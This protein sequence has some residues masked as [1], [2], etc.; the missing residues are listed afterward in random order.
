M[1]ANQIIAADDTRSRRPVAG[2]PRVFPITRDVLK[3]VL[4]ILIGVVMAAPFLWM[5]STSLKPPDQI[6]RIPPEWIPSRFVWRNYAEAWTAV[7]FHLFLLNSTKVSGLAVM[8]ALFVCS[9]AGY[10][11]AKVKFPGSGVVFGFLLATLMI[12]SAVRLIP[13]YI[14]FRRIGWID[15]HYTLIVPPVVASTFGTFLMRQFFITLPSEL[16][17]SAWVDGCGVW[18][19]YWRIMLPLA[20]PGLGVLAIFMFMSSWNE[21]LGPLIFINT[22]EK[23]TAPLGLAAFQGEYGTLWGPLMAGSTII[24]LPV[25]IVYLLFQRTFTEGIALSGLK[26]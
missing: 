3:Y 2:S 14:V 12:P 23:M 4:M 6:A 25:T 16:E 21:L 9:L 22:P 10:S 1:A 24:M 26:Q 15:T 7:P 5:I 8:G 17:D 13:L 18:S 11:F 19:S 20:K